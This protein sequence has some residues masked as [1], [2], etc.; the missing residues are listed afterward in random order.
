LDIPSLGED[1]YQ[2]NV[3]GGVGDLFMSY[4]DWNIDVFYVKIN[5]NRMI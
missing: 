1:Y 3:E 5:A 4:F 2:A